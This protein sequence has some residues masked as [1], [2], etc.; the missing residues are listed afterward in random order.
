MKI[1][2]WLD[3]QLGID[4]SNLRAKGMPVNN[5]AKTTSGAVSFMETFSQVSSV[6]GQEGRRKH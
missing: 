1:N 5:A 2:E 6:I 3:S 4:I